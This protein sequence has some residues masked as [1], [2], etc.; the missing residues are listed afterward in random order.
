MGRETFSGGFV[1]LRTPRTLLGLI[2]PNLVINTD[3][4]LEGWGAHDEIIATGGR[5]LDSEAD[6]HI[7]V[8][9]LQAILLGLKSLA[10]T[11]KPHI[12]ILTDNTTAMAYIRNMGGTRSKPCNQLAKLIWEWAEQH[13]VWLTVA[14]IPGCQNKIADDRSRN[15]KDHLEWSLSNKIFNIVV[16]HWGM[17]DVDR[18]MSCRNHK[19]HKFVSWHPELEAC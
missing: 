5:W 6:A 2:E 10:K 3:V 13:R 7:N 17:P 9:E 8:L 11:N 1:T 15:F 18:F 4:S 19:L 16:S 12:R 14:H